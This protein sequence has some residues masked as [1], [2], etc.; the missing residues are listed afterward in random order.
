MG[1]TLKMQQQLEAYDL[2]EVFNDNRAKFLEAAKRTHHFVTLSFPED[3]AIRR[4]DVADA[5]VSMLEVH[6]ELQEALTLRKLK[7]K[8]WAK[9]F[10]HYIVDQVW[11]EIS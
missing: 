5:M 6:E 9:Y 1:L 11:E 3:S 7:Q 4:D 10:A 2:H 8:Y